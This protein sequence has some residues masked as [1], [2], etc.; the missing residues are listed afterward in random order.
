MV[1]GYKNIEAESVEL[2]PFQKL[3]AT[4]FLTAALAT[5]FVALLNSSPLTESLYEEEEYSLI[6]PSFANECGACHTLYPPFLLPAGSWKRIMADLENHFG[7]DASLEEEERRAIENFLV[8]RSAQN[9]TKEAAFYILKS[10]QGREPLAITETPFWKEKHS[11]ISQESF[12]RAR[13]KSN[14][15][16]CHRNIEK[17]MIEDREIRLPK[18]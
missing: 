1:T 2:T 7:D 6:H 4:L 13:S 18:G 12:K 3:L 10:L 17:G 14:C 16:A 11:S 8:Q 15:K 9:S 5:P